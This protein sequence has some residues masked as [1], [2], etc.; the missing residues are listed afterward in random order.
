MTRKIENEIAARYGVKVRAG[1]FQK[2]PTGEMAVPYDHM[3]TPKEAMSRF[4]DNRRRAN[5]LRHAAAQETRDPMDD[6]DRI[7]IRM[8]EEGATTAEIAGQVSRSTTSVRTRQK[9]M[10]LK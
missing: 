6:I 10:G 3:T 7:I 4:Y 9:R 2:C 5:A 8:T 1:A